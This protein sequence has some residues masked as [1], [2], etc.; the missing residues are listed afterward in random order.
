LFLVW[1][2]RPLLRSCSWYTCFLFTGLPAG[3]LALHHRPFVEPPLVRHK[4]YLLKLRNE[5]K[6]RSGER[7]Y[8]SRIAERGSTALQ[9]GFPLMKES[10]VL[11]QKWL[12]RFTRCQAKFPVGAFWVPSI[13]CCL[14]SVT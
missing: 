7:C 14:T 5:W 8:L 10:Q 1:L 6:N 2:K 13:T 9:S 11:P 12:Y 4:G 3:A